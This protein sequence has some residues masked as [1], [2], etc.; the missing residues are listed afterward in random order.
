MLALGTLL[1]AQSSPFEVGSNVISLGV[2][3]GSSWGYASARQTPAFNAQFERGIAP[4]GPGVISLG[5]YLGYKGYSY[6]SNLSNGFF[7]EQ[8]WAYRIVGVR[9]AWHLTE[10][11][12]VN[13]TKWDLYGGI[14]IGFHS[15]KYT[16]ED[17]DPLFDYSSNTYGN[18]VGWSSF[19]GARYFL[20]DKLAL[21]GELGYGISYL[22]L[23]VAFKF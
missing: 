19:L 9:A 1:N 6:R 17:N 15:V 2:G 7:Y 14:M 18:G 8:N 22:S 5:G 12:G 4:L 3:V 10:L 16:Y 23:G 11:E 21:Q 13:L 20:T